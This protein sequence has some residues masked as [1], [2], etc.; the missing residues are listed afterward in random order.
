MV[1]PFGMLVPNRHGSSDSYRYGFNGKEK[2]DEIKGVGVQYDYGFRIYDARIGKFLSQDPL[3][4]SYPQLTPYQFAQND[5]VRNIDIDGLEGGSRTQFENIGTEWWDNTKK[6]IS[7][8]LDE[9]FSSS[10]TPG[11]PDNAPN[12]PAQPI[13]INNSKTALKKVD[14]KT[15]SNTN[16]SQPVAQLKASTKLGEFAEKY[17]GLSLVI[18]DDNGKK[19]GGF[20]TIGIGHLIH[21]GLPGT[22]PTAEE[23][24]A[25]GITREKAFELYKEDMQDAETAVKQYVTVDLTQNQYDA[26][27]SFTFN[28]GP[29]NFKNSTLLKKVNSQASADEITNEFKKWINSDGQKLSGLY[30]RRRD[31]AEIYNES[32]YDRDYNDTNSTLGW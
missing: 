24:F 23:P 28:T 20:A 21:K 9:A 30:N 4:Q 27:V 11:L 8:W 2:D 26:L 1:Y 17:E 5:P 10:S 18:Y 6:G 22:N 7:K 16:T 13:K 15:L 14:T 25:N 19:K 32:D 31:E 12:K 3:F 29:I